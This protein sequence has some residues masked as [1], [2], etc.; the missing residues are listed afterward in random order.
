MPPEGV[1][2]IDDIELVVKTGA[3]AVVVGRALYEGSVDLTEAIE[4]AAGG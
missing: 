1:S 4:V 3:E 2:R